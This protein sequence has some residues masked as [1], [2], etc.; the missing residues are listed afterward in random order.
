M[1]RVKVAIFGTV[2]KS[3]NIDPTATN[4]AQ[5]G[6][7]FYMPGGQLATADLLAS[8][9]GAVA[10]T[11][12]T[13]TQNHKLLQGLTVGN[14]HPQYQLKA[15]LTTRGDLYYRGASDVGPLALGT[16]LQVL[17]SNGTDL[18]YATVSPT[19][20][21]T[22]N[23]TGAGTL[24]NLGNVSFAATI[25]ANAVTD[26][27]LRDSVGLSVIGRASDT[28]GDP[29]DVVA[30]NDGEVLRRS[31]TTLGFGQI[32]Q[33]AVTNLS[34]DLTAIR[35]ITTLTENDETALFPSSRRLLPG[36]DVAF[37]DTVPGVRT[38]NATGGGGG[39]S[40]V[41]VQTEA[42]TSRTI[43]ATDYAQ[44]VRF[45]SG[46]AIAYTVPKNAT[47]AV[48]IGTVVGVQQAGAGQVTLT[49]EDG[50][51]TII[52]PSGKQLYTRAVGAFAAIHKVA[53]NT[54][55]L[56]GDLAV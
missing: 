12:P 23:V 26:A 52:G 50:T 49:P 22:G 31:G 28:S 21:L 41:G 9:I 13:T 14:D 47:L 6:V 8:Y 24:T 45:T 3:V 4:G 11:Q 43:S 2:G 39:S 54:W 7:N 42:G 30:A 27:R 33:A 55:E 38:I 20:T 34:T 29:A 15:V 48:P 40:T 46:S 36:T 5:L 32:T 44:K 16:N 17:R 19:V 51:V 35:A 1:S 25:A 18:V 37:D 56:T 53:T 10:S